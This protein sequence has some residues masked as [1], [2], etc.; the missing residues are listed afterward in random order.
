MRFE[1]VAGTQGGRTLDQALD[2]HTWRACGYVLRRARPAFSHEVRRARRNATE[3]G[4]RDAGTDDNKSEQ[5]LRA[6]EASHST[7]LLR[8]LR[9]AVSRT[10][11]FARIALQRD[12]CRTR[13]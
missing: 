5:Y 1:Q 11:T 6:G 9:E 8:P 7:F 10:I 12:A 3:L 2:L 13:L 4:D